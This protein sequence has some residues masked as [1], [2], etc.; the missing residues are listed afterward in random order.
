MN[1]VMRGLGATNSKVKKEV[2]DLLVKKTSK[3]CKDEV[4]TF[5]DSFEEELKKENQFL[6]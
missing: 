1:K 4:K 5:D 2:P 3:Y 6:M